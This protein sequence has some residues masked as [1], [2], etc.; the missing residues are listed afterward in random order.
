MS[1]AG[2]VQYEKNLRKLMASEKF[3]SADDGEKLKYGFSL[4]KSKYGK[5]SFSGKVE[6]VKTNKISDEEIKE[7]PLFKGTKKQLEDLI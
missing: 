1:L 7:I 4:F 2:I 6:E 5:G 3:K